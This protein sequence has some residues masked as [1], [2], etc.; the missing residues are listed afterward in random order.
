MLV[1]MSMLLTQVKDDEEHVV[2]HRREK[3]FKILI[4]L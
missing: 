1:K 2:G 3:L 4:K